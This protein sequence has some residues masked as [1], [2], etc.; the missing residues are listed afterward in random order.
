M[1]TYIQICCFLPFP[2]SFLHVDLFCY[3][4][5]LVRF[6]ESCICKLQNSGHTLIHSRSSFLRLWCKIRFE[7]KVNLKS[8]K[9]FEFENRT[10][11][12]DFLLKTYFFFGWYSFGLVKGKEVERRTLLVKFQT[13]NFMLFQPFSI[14]NFN[15]WDMEWREMVMATAV[16]NDSGKNE[17][18]LVSCCADMPHFLHPIMQYIIST[19]AFYADIIMKPCSLSRVSFSTHI[20]TLC[21]FG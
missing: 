5:R 10:W 21:F 8:W 16:W 7:L 11:L 4:W 14:L 18:V 13:F 6:V 1:Y 19:T 20:H 2:Y 12:V 17:C 3:G 9:N 15:L